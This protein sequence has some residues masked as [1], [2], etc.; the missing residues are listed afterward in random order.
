[1][2]DASAGDP[3]ILTTRQVTELLKTSE[4]FV[5]RGVH[6]G[7]IPASRIGFEW[8]YWRPLVLVRVLHAPEPTADPATECEPAEVLTAA[9]LAALFTMSP[10]TMSA[11]IADG[12]IPA[13]KVGKGW[14]IH[15]PTVRGRLE[16]G[17][18]F[19]PGD[20]TAPR[21]VNCRMCHTPLHHV[22]TT[23]IGDLGWRDDHENR[24]CPAREMRNGGLAEHLE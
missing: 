10:H 2:I 17:E 1:M 20:F 3:R 22:P 15:W 23:E 7:T 12:S 5:M 4:S 8:R 14:R 11:R 21:K 19:D 9:E 18:S 13:R 24:W 16:R 6:Q